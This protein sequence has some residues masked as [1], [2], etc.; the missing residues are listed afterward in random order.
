MNLHAT[1]TAYRK[2]A[3]RTE[4]FRLKRNQAIR[5]AVANGTPQAQVARIT[6]MTR[7]RISQIVAAAERS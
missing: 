4:A 7:G 6:G 3:E 2:S 1:E 5:E